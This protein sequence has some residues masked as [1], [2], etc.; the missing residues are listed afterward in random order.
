M[1]VYIQ[2]LKKDCLL[3]PLCCV[4]EAHGTPLYSEIGLDWIGLD[5]SD[6]RSCNYNYKTERVAIF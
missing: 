5:T 2:Y 6:W 4:R 1:L 3:I